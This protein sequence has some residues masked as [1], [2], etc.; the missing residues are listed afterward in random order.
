MEGLVATLLFQ[1]FFQLA[2]ERAEL[3]A[4]QA[5]TGDYSH[6]YPQSSKPAEV[7]ALLEE[8]KIGENRR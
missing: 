7:L 5:A 8:L 2:C 6:Y 4:Q 1:V 3:V